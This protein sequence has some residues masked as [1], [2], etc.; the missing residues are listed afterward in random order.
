MHKFD[1][2]KERI[3]G[4]LAMAHA[5]AT[6]CGGKGQE[7]LP[8]IKPGMPEWEAWKQYFHNHMGFE[9]YAMTRVSAELGSG[10]MTVPAQWPQDFDASYV[11]PR[12]ATG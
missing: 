6:E 3:Y 1:L 11:P 5:R 2:K 7:P 4:K 9:P 10:E 12:L 8:T